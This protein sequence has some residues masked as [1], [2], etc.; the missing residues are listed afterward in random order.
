MDKEDQCVKR[1]NGAFVL[2]IALALPLS[3]RAVDIVS[4]PIAEGHLMAQYLAMV[5]EL[6]VLKDQLDNARSSLKISTSQLEA[7]GQGSSDLGK[8]HFEDYMAA[9]PKSWQE[10]LDVMNGE[11]RSGELARGIRDENSRLDRSYFER[12]DGRAK[13]T[14]SDRMNASSNLEGVAASSYQGS[15][16]RFERLESLRSDVDRATDLKAVADLQARIQ[17]ENG[18]LMNELVKLQSMSAMHEASEKVKSQR[19]LQES[20]EQESVSY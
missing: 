6:A 10:T 8:D 20:F 13:S 12:V 2:A 3:S 5:E 17:I 16:D 18:M 1:R 4:D 19:R 9:V 11:G 7:L 15:T 14:L